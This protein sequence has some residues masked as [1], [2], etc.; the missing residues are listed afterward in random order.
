[1]ASIWT[2]ISVAKLK[3]LVSKG[4]SAREI[5]NELG[6]GFTRNSVIGK[7]HRLDLSNETMPKPVKEPKIRA[8]KLINIAP[9]SKPM[10]DLPNQVTGL[11]IPFMSMRRGMCWYPVEETDGSHKFCGMPSGIKSYCPDH[12]KI[13]YIPKERRRNGQ[14]VEVREK[15][16]RLLSNTGLGAFNFARKTPA[17]D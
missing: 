15:S 1:M 4:L 10:R 17:R 13:V 2:D 5:A 11:V 6:Q 12:H 7:M 8:P 14:T 9:V 3:K 16:P